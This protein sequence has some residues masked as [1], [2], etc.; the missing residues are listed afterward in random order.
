M[1]TNSLSTARPVESTRSGKPGGRKPKK[2]FPQFHAH[3]TRPKEE[4][5]LVTRPYQEKMIM[6]SWPYLL[7]SGYSDFFF[8]WFTLDL[9]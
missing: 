6:V 1:K 8:S 5:F 3:L 7:E 9:S 4:Q 2:S